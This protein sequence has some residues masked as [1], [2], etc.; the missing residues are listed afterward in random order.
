MSSSHNTSAFPCPIAVGP[1]GDIY[2]PDQEQMG[3]TLRD[4][5]AAFA[6]QAIIHLT[7]SQG[8]EGIAKRA[9][10]MADVMLKVRQT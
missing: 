10:S 5:F 8:E 9:Y 6:L 7:A 3:M 2:Q 1:A 4:Y